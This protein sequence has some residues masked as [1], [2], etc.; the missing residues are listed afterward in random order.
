MT[1]FTIFILPLTSNIKGKSNEYKIARL[2]SAYKGII[3]KEF[4]QHGQSQTHG[5]KQEKCV[6]VSRVKRIPSQ[7]T[8]T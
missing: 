8:K 3:R 6:H 1:I 5:N 2:V 7:V 4:V